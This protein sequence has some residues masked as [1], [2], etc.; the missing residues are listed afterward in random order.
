MNRRLLTW[1]LGAGTGVL[2][3]TVLLLALTSGGAV[4]AVGKEKPK[5]HGKPAPKGA[6]EFFITASEM[7][8]ENSS[9]GKEAIPLPTIDPAKLSDA[10][11]LEKTGA[12]TYEVKE[13]VFM[14]GALT[15]HQGDTVA[16]RI[17]IVEGKHKV[18]VEDPNGYEVI[19]VRKM[20]AGR[21]YLW[22]FKATQLGIYH[23]IC[24]NHDPTMKTVI[25]VLRKGA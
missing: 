1:L 8:A 4:G 16:L 9:V 12:S 20:L 21:E 22:V 3:L 17:F 2:L 19:K 13:D 5:P 18:W 14:P 11:E 15:V 6:I 24:D 10:Y 23:L 7:E 25:T